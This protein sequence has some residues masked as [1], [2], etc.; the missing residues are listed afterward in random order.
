MTL[1]VR[2]IQL[3]RYAYLLDVRYLF[4]FSLKK[5]GGKHARGGI[6]VVSLPKP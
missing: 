1:F 6:K 3:G 5:E 2:I 4:H